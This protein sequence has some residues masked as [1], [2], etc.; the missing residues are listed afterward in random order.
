MFSRGLIFQTVPNAGLPNAGD[1][2]HKADLEYSFNCSEVTCNMSPICLA[3]S[4]RSR[5]ERRQT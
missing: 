3:I 4:R 2:L 1:K 5:M